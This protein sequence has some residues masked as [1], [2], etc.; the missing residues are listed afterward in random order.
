MANLIFKDIEVSNFISFGDLPQ[1]YKFNESG[2]ALI[3]GQ[4][5]DI[6]TLFD[7][8]NGAGKSSFISALSW[9]LFGELD[10]KM[11]AGD[12][13]NNI[14]ERDC[15]VRI[16]FVNAGSIASAVIKLWIRSLVLFS[17]Q[18]LMISA[19]CCIFENSIS[20]ISAL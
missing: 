16:N 17:T 20:F 12:V 4:N 5:K 11:K 9:G 2:L 10:K 6:K 8:S 18:W 14:N 15:M 13:V 7:S 1:K 3:T 19:A